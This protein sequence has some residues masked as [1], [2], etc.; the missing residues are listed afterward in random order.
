MR[1]LPAGG[2][3]VHAIPMRKRERT[4]GM[5]DHLFHV[6]PGSGCE[7][8]MGADTGVQRIKLTA[9]VDLEL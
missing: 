6:A 5:T 9:A 4:R 7:R 3:A 8:T 2:F 1:A